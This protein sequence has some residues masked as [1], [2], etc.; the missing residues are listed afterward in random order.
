MELSIGRILVCPAGTPGHADKQIEI[1]DLYRLEARQNEIAS[2]N[3]VTAPELMQAFINGYGIASRALIQLQY[4]LAVANKHI[5]ERK[6]IL[7]LDVVPQVLK[8][9]G[10]VRPSNPAGSEDLRKS[11]MIQDKE[12]R[13]LK[14]RVDMIE[15]AV[16]F[17]KVKA[18]GFEMA[19]QSVK[20]V[21][22]NLSSINALTVNRPSSASTYM[23]TSE[24]AAIGKP[25]Y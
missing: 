24:Q 22:D 11:V 4:E 9:K 23:D 1:V 15:T 8:E 7:I 5:E 21:Y 10:L 20:K 12:Y 18:K 16:E 19:Y 25:R 13:E 3:K 14:D 2:V 6:A 17:L